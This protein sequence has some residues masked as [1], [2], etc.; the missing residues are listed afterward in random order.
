MRS[1]T[2]IRRL[3][4]WQKTQVARHPDR[5]HAKHYVARLITDFTPLAGDRK[6]GEDKAI[7]AGLGRF[8]GEPVAIIC[9]GEGR[10]HAEPA[11][12]TISAWRGRRATARPS[13]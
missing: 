8:R 2:S 12:R 5:P 3:T 11:A 1:P 7:V 4:P 6:F 13:A 9:A 10:G